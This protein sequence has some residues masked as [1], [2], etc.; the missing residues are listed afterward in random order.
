MMPF[1]LSTVRRPSSK[2]KSSIFVRRLAYTGMRESRQAVKSKEHADER[3]DSADIEY[4]I[5]ASHALVVFYFSTFTTCQCPTFGFSS[6][7]PVRGGSR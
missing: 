6:L 5:L 1:S 7:V 2:T 3:D 4:K